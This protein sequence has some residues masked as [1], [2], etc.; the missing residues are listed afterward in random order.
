[1]TIIY[2]FKISPTYNVTYNLY[3]SIEKYAN[4]LGGK[5]PSIHFPSPLILLGVWR[6]MA[7]TSGIFDLHTY[8]WSGQS[9][10]LWKYLRCYAIL[11]NWPHLLDMLGNTSRI[12]ITEN[13]TNSFIIQQIRLN[14]HTDPATST[15]FSSFT[16][17]WLFPALLSLI[18]AWTGV[19]FTSPALRSGL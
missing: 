18:L 14:R 2:H 4:L 13:D 12:W 15:F 10:S 16:I 1:M 6:I 9:R 17:L 5:N 19:W 3:D 7:P 8:I 11:A